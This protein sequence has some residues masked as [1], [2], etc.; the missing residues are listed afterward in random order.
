MSQPASIGSDPS[1]EYLSDSCLYLH[2][3]VDY[4]GG[5]I[6]RLRKIMVC[7]CVMSALLLIGFDRICIG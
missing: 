2:G 1:I 3:R 5:Q 4:V 7:L 6:M